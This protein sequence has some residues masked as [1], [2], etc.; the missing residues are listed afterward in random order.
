MYRLCVWMPLLV[1]AVV[2]GL[3]HGLGMVVEV[4]PA[5]KVVQ[6]LLGSLLYG[7]VPYAALALWATWWIG[8]KDERQ[9]KRLMFV[10]PLLMVSL[11][12]VLSTTVGF[13]V[14]QP[15]AFITLGVIGALVIIPLGY[16]YV[17]LVL[18]L[19]DEVGSQLQSRISSD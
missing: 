2:A 3:V 8:G 9:I 4:G 11:F 12:L 10:A 19:R 7:G 1:P 13:V 17:G 5:S 18:L 6:V 16:G 14:G 15:V